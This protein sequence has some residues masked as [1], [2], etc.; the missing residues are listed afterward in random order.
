MS[1]LTHLSLFT[2]IG[3]L[4]LAGEW[5]GFTTVGQCEFADFPYSILAK[6]WSDVPKWRD[7]RT[8][9]GENFYERTGLR[10]VDIISGGFPCQP[11]SVA[12][13][14]L[15][16]ADDRYLWPQMLRVIKELRPTW[17]IGENVAGIVS[18]AEP[19]GEPKVENRTVSRYAGEDN[20]CAVLSQQERMLLDGILSDIEKA[21]YEVQPFIIPACAV[22]APHQR[23]RIFIVGHRADALEN[24]GCSG[25]SKSEDVCEQ[26][27]RAEFKRN[28][29]I[30]A[31]A[32]RIS[33]NA[34]RPESAGQQRQAGPA[35]GSYDV[36]YATGEG[37]IRS[38]R[39]ELSSESRSSGS[40]EDV[41]DTNRHGC[42]QQFI[43]PFEGR[44]N[45]DQ[46]DLVI[47]ENCDVSH[48]KGQR[49][50]GHNHASAIQADRP[51][52]GQSFAT[53]GT[54]DTN[55]DPQ[56]CERDGGTWGRRPKSANGGW[57][58][59]EPDVGRVANGVPDRVDRLKCLGNAVVPQQAYPIFRAIAEIERQAVSA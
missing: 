3:G 51:G 10:T 53:G 55:T 9:T 40:R 17:I 28:G 43:N 4:D 41:A 47:A 48:T 11:F 39:A 5:A 20:Y 38:A 54:L 46:V 19:I 18:M 26:P 59:V 37:R 1:P 24:S 21:G 56:Q 58:S 30:L 16:K 25:R 12:G 52:E 32:N 33:G 57:W 2:G 14:R 36:A 49:F 23:S 22:E 7:I 45:A 13:K 50:Q 29:E 35:N 8:L 34:R 42:K 44:C 6:R 31:N 15:G 27:W